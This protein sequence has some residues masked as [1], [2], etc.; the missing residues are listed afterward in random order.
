MVQ[1]SAWLALD[2]DVHKGAAI[3]EDALGMRV[4]PSQLLCA[5]SFGVA[6]GR[7]HRT[8]RLPSLVAFGPFIRGAR[9]NHGC[10]E[11]KL[12][13]LKNRP[14]RQQALVQ[15]QQTCTQPHLLATR[16]ASRG[17]IHVAEAAAA[18]GDRIGK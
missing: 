16:D 3:Y 10:T 8:V 7:L 4:L 12:I 15:R 9:R 14:Q 18:R 6:F 17:R 13:R 11:S 2:S 5:L 1:G